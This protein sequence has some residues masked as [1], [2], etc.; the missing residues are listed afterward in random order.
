MWLGCGSD[1]ARMSL[2]RVFGCGRKSLAEVKGKGFPAH[3]RA[4]ADAE[5]DPKGLKVEKN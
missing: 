3:R 1:I 2:G 4:S 5:K